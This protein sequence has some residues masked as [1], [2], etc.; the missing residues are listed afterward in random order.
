MSIIKNEQVFPQQKMTQYF[1]N[2]TGEYC[3]PTHIIVEGTWEEMGYDLATIGRD[4]FGVQLKKYFDPMYGEARRSYME[5]HYPEMIE[6]QKGVFKAFGL[7]E[8]NNEYDGTSLAFD[9]YDENYDGFDMGSLKTCSNAV[10]PKEKTDN[11]S[12]YVSR[13]YDMSA[14]VLWSPL[15]GKPAPEGAWGHAE[16]WVVVEFRPENGP[17]TIMSGTN[18]LLTPYVDAINEHGLF[19]TMLRD[20]E[21][22]GKEAGPSS[23]GDIAGLAN[24]HILHQLVSTCKTVEEAKKVLLESRVTQTFLNFHIPIVDR[25]G[26]ATVFEIDKHSGAYVFTDREEGEPFFVTNHAVHL[27]PTP[28]TYP[29]TPD[30]AAHNTYT[31][32][33]ILR[34]TYKNFEG[35][36]NREHATQLMDA[37]HCAFVDEELAEA[38]PSERSLQ[39]I[40][41]D[42]T[43]AEIRIR[44]YLGDKGPI[45]GTENDLE[46]IRSEWVTFGF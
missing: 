30:I 21:T 34:E 4:Q 46:D 17:K 6:M 28:D 19:V 37:V 27:H 11:G 2:K 40:N 25:E 14:L 43:K 31:R 42:L 16:R 35:P 39:E 3:K 45:E 20:P 5:K 12:T 7:P 13:N 1:P 44:W 22:I 38:G 29:D 36:L 24:T 18:E 32:Q 15:F 41:A 23:G 8:D 9:W 10:L 26:N 33:R